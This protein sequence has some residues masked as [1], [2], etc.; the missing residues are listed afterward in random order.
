MYHRFCA[1]FIVVCFAVAAAGC[2][3][4][5]QRDKEVIL[6]PLQTGSSLN[7]RIVVD[8]ESS[9]K[10][11]IERESKPSSKK[12]KKTEQREVAPTEPEKPEETPTPPEKFR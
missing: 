5:S 7:R 6:L 8:E 3:S 10:K 11:V 1:L 2:A 4:K 9:F 12:K